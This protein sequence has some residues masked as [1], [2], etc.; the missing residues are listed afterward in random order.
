MAVSRAVYLTGQANAIMDILDVTDNIYWNL[1]DVI[2]RVEHDREVGGD[3]TQD[4]KL[5]ILSNAIGQAVGLLCSELSEA[6]S[7]LIM[8]SSLSQ[9]ILSF[10]KLFS[11]TL[12][13]FLDVATLTDLC[14]SRLPEKAFSVSKQLRIIPAE[15]G[16]V[17]I[18]IGE[19][20]LEPNKVREVLPGPA[21]ILWD[22]WLT[23]FGYIISQ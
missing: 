11:S 14:G 5:Y 7:I 21:F 9:T 20:Y 13:T 23:R 6:V 4:V 18:I 3:T 8:L 10:K 17:P 15:P 2:C 1:S 12:C 19:F 16:Q 22:A